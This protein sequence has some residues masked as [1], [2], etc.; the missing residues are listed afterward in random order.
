MAINE[1]AQCTSVDINAAIADIAIFVKHDLQSRQVELVLNLE[2]GLPAVFGDEVQLQQVMHNLVRN[3]A[4][5][6]ADGQCPLRCITVSTAR[7]GDHIEIV[8]EDTGPGI[9]PE[10]IDKLFTA[11]ETTKAGGMGIGLTLCRSIVISHGGTI[12]P[13]V[14]VCDG[15]RFRIT[16]PLQVDP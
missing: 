15:A 1:A 9:P 2:D 16:L 4:Q 7:R 5:A 8:V 10:Q 13:D 12:E 14:S 11:F 3:S 6:I